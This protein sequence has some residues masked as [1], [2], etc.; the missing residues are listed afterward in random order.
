[1]KKEESWMK[2]GLTVAELIA[3]LLIVQAA[4]FGII[5]ILPGD[6]FARPNQVDLLSR[7]AT[8]TVWGAVLLLIAV[9]MLAFRGF[10]H[11]RLH[12]AGHALLWTFWLGI[13]LL[14]IYRS[15][16]G[17]VGLTPAS[18][19]IILPFFAIALIHG[20]LYVSLGREP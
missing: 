12:R 15:L 2:T 7:Y 20:I 5:L 6:L 9:P 18:F 13:C 4:A 19:L 1:M 8:D 17:A 16:T 11:R 10:R 14:A 3:L